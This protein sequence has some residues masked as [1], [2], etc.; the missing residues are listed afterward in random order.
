MNPFTA[1]L[2][3][4]PEGT[5]PERPWWAKYGAFYARCDDLHPPVTTV[6]EMD[7]FDAAHPRPAP[8]PM[9]GQVWAWPNGMTGVVGWVYPGPQAPEIPVTIAHGVWTNTPWP[10]PGA[11]LVAGPTE[12]GRDVPW[13]PPGWRP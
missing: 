12:Q 10:P 7:A 4:Y 8:R 3:M 1:W 13:A 11:V 2:P 5:H 9:S 6:A